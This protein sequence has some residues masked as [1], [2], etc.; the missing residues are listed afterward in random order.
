MSL[1]I[2]D[3]TGA[4]SDVPA[5]GDLVRGD[6]IACHLGDR[7]GNVV[8]RMKRGWQLPPSFS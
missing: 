1:E 4:P 7:L 8:D 2:R 6:D 5:A 3:M